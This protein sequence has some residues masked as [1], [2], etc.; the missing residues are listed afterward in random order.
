MF[1]NKYN[2]RRV[3]FID[4]KIKY[5]SRQ[6]VKYIYI[7]VILT[8]MLL[9]VGYL[10]FKP[11]FVVKLNGQEIGLVNNNV[12]VES[13]LNSFLEKPVAPVEVATMD[14]KPEFELKFAAK[15]VIQTDEE[16]VKEVIDNN[17]E[18]TYKV[19]EIKANNNKIAEVASE[20]EAKQIKEEIEKERGY[21]V[22]Y[23]P[24]LT[25]KT[26]FTEK[27]KAKE[28]TIA[29]VSEI[30]EVERKEKVKKRE[31]AER[32]TREIAMLSRGGSMRTSISADAERKL[33]SKGLGRP[34]S[35]LR[36][37]IGYGGYPGHTGQDILGGGLS[38]YATGSGIVTTV[39]D[40][41]NRSYGRYIIIDHGD[42]V[43]TLY[44]HCS[45]LKVTLGQRVTKGQVIG[46]TGN[47]GRSTGPHLHYEI[48]LNGRRINPRPY[49]P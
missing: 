34:L 43:A 28:I 27:N 9:F 12:K 48:R 23:N 10:K 40:L 1:L 6:A 42:G 15:G 35:T 47:T 8:F 11:V 37:G 18:K 3:A 5:Y 22:S 13:E 24:T 36:Y 32:R 38:I 31:E 19:Y 29:K 4:K 26:E 2:K 17:I 14:E 25:K 20:E 45:M 16:K 44:A 39:Q 46:I 33:L 49:I 41:G 7:L 21:E 30:Q